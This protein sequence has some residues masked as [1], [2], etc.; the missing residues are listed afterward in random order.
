MKLKPEKT[1]LDNFFLNAF[2]N[3][4][5][6]ILKICGKKNRKGEWAC[7]FC[8]SGL[9][10]NETSAFT[11][12]DGGHGGFYCFSCGEG[13][14]IFHFV[15]KLYGLPGFL[16]QVRKACELLGK[17][18]PESDSGELAGGNVTP[19]TADFSAYI[20]ASMRR[21]QESPCG[22]EYLHSRG[23][24]DDSI[25]TFRLGFDR[26]EK[27]GRPVDAIVIPYDREN[28]YYA[29]R[30]LEDCH[31][32]VHDKPPRGTAGAEPLF[33][34]EALWNS[35]HE[36]V[37][38]T[39]SAFDA[40]SIEQLGYRAIAMGGA[41][42]AKLQHA[43]EARKTPVGRVLI[44][45]GDND[46]PGQ[47]NAL[48]LSERLSS[49]GVR[50]TR[51]NITA[52]LGCK[53]ANEALVAAPE[54]FREILAR[55]SKLSNLSGIAPDNDLV[56]LDRG[57]WEDKRAFMECR[58]LSTGFGVLD[59]RLGGGVYPGLYVLGAATSLG[60]TSF[61]H[62]VA[63]HL[64]HIGANVLFFSLEMSKFEMISRGIAREIGR[65]AA[66]INSSFSSLNIRKLPVNDD[67]TNGI[68]AYKKLTDGR[69]NIIQCDFGYTV[70]KVIE[71]TKNFMAANRGVA[72]ILFIDYLQILSQE[73]KTLHNSV[74]REEIDAIIT[75]LKLF[76]SVHKIPIFVVSSLNRGNYI[77]PV[78]YESFKESGGIEY[79]ADVVLGLQ[80]KCLGDD[81]FFDKEGKISEK[82]KKIREHMNANPRRIELLI[83]KNRFGVSS[84]SIYY[85]YYCNCDYFCNERA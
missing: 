48:R 30:F 9:R 44:I 26:V 64:A 56:Y 85:D 70:E 61:C 43:L 67:I 81:D 62:Q 7:P 42:D 49:M 8:D 28:S 14:D 15:G 27:H 25:A 23:F 77:L 37:F 4:F 59:Q 39:E 84:G 38:V 51:E 58:A 69:L 66:I 57:F 68:E 50:H 2:R 74:K 36:P 65:R 73:N 33:N 46:H 80:L 5:Q 13:G 55:V 63:S 75:S 3:K 20:E 34:R 22:L 31:G 40:I 21:L 79:T 52:E 17:P 10:K 11:L 41:G 12:Y 29:L 35:G 83:L 47:K 45:S 76:S 32:Q 60:K 6:E 24:S 1:M 18:F 53:D 71:Y 78:S 72:T 54:K 16:D 82:R 19:S